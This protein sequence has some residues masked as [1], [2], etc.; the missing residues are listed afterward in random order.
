MEDRGEGRRMEEEG[1]GI[2]DDNGRRKDARG[3][4]KVEEREGSQRK[5]SFRLRP[6]GLVL[7]IRTNLVGAANNELARSLAWMSTRAEWR[8]GAAR[9][10]GWIKTTAG[11][12]KTDCIGAWTDE[13]AGSLAW[14]G[15]A[16]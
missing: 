4:R 2:A 5:A 11:I 15:R 14:T 16:E 7:D 10:T 1:V 13:R 12:R 3:I 9:A 6:E 8:R